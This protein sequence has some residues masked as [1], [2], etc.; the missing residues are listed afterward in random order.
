MPA[1]AEVQTAILSPTNSVP[2]DTNAPTGDV[3]IDIITFDE[4][5]LPDAIRQLALLA[6]LNIQF[7]HKLENQ[8]DPV[9]KAPIA[10]PTVKEKWKNLTAKQ[11]LQAVLNKYDWQMKPVPSSPSSSSAPRKPTRSNP[12]CRR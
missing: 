11:A 10:P 3:L 7:D 12:R 1:P 6:G 8:V 5:P 9:T 2:G 4:E